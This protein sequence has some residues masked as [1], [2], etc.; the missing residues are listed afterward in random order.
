MQVVFGSLEPLDKSVLWLSLNISGLSVAL[1]SKY[2]DETLKAWKE[3][4]LSSILSPQDLQDIKNRLLTLEAHSNTINPT[5]LQQIKTDV[6]NAV[7]QYINSNIKPLIDANKASIADNKATLDARKPMIEQLKNDVATIKNT[8]IPAINGRLNGVGN[9]V[10]LNQNAISA[11][12]TDNTANKAQI[13]TNK[14]DIGNLKTDVNNLKTR[15]TAV[16]GKATSLQQ[17]ISTLTPK[18]T[19]NENNIRNNTNAITSLKGSSVNLTAMEDMLSYGV[20]FKTLDHIERVGNPTLSYTL[21][22]HNTLRN[23]MIEGGS[24]Y[25]S[26]RGNPYHMGDSSYKEGFA[27]GDACV[28]WKSFY[29]KVKVDNT[30]TLEIRLSLY[31]ISNEYQLFPMGYVG[32]FFNSINKKQNKNLIY[33]DKEVRVGSYDCKNCEIYGKVEATPTDNNFSE[34]DCFIIRPDPNLHYKSAH[35]NNRSISLFEYITLFWLL[36][37]TDKCNITPYKFPN[38]PTK[39]HIQTGIGYAFKHNYI[40]NN[41]FL[42]STLSTS[43]VN[44]FMYTGLMLERKQINPTTWKID[45]NLL[46]RGICK[47]WSAIPTK[48]NHLVMLQD[49]KRTL[50]IFPFPVAA[51]LNY[52][53]D[54]LSNLYIDIPV[55]KGI[56][57]YNK[58]KIYNLD[59]K[60]Q[61]LFI[62]FDSPCT[63][64]EAICVVEMD[65]FSNFTD[66]IVNFF[67]GGYLPDSI[68]L[69]FNMQFLI[70]DTVIRGERIA[71]DLDGSAITYKNAE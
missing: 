15:V 71:G 68:G 55:R 35:N 47:P 69:A 3:I 10:N 51:N 18:V 29:Y 31:P 9:Q 56:S 40:A 58:F 8:T 27:E 14:T 44:T 20:R 4:N 22:V 53:K 16:E 37:L 42:F 54:T 30:G 49:D 12:N 23:C 24:P 7:Q 57:Y 66:K 67:I 2:Y 21:P 64:N 11:L 19:T 6:T 60:L 32:A 39:L 65:D 5:Q 1:I 38:D 50:R 43:L 26:M 46:Y 48:I 33:P 17:G 45:H 70:D 63:K 34:K 59:N 36:P 62:D 13:N 25:A 28:I 52:Y 41:S 61:F